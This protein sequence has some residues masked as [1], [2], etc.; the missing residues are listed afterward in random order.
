MKFRYAVYILFAL[1]F[2]ALFVGFTPDK[3]ALKQDNLDKTDS[4]IIVHVQKAT[5]SQW[6]TVGDNKGDYDIPK[7]IR[8]TGNAPS[9]YNYDVEV[10]DNAFVCYG[11]FDGVGDLNGEEYYVFNV[12]RWEILYPVKRNSPFDWILPNSYLC[13]FDREA[14]TV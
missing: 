6:I 9:G 5:I 10:G 3:K 11:K 4:Y 1:V 2:I 13:R 14:L 8:L 12:D 7:D